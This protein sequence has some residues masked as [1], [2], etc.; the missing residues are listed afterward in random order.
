VL[1]EGNSN[2]N[3]T[4]PTDTA[5]LLRSLSRRLLPSHRRSALAR[6]AGAEIGRCDAGPPVEPPNLASTIGYDGKLEGHLVLRG[7]LDRLARSGEQNAVV[8]IRSRYAKCP[9]ATILCFRPT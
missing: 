5:A 6:V 8:G 7:T 1:L 3:A 9:A 4:P 2:L